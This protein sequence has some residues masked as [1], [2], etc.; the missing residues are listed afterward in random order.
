MKK[1]IGFGNA[2]F[3]VLFISGAN[4]AFSEPSLTKEQILLSSLFCMLALY[5][6]PEARPIV[7]LFYLPAFSF[8]M[9]RLTRRQYLFLAG[10]VMGLYA[11]VLGI[12]YFKDRQGVR[13][14]YE[15][16]LFTLYCVF[17]RIV[18]THS[19]GL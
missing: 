9:L 11:I 19:A 3:L 13:I 6:L 8:G 18:T 15:L 1:H 4:L 7:L 12:E 17:R 2:I 16:F 14:Q 5:S 10:C